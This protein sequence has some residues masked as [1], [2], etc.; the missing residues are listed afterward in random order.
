MAA[1]VQEDEVVAGFLEHGSVEAFGRGLVGRLASAAAVANE[2][3]EGD[4]FNFLSTASFAGPDS[5]RPTMRKMQNRLL[6]LAQE[7][8]NHELPRNPPRVDDPTDPEDVTDRFEAVVDSTDLL[9]EKV[10]NFADEARGQSNRPKVVVTTT[11][12]QEKGRDFHL[13]H[14]SNVLRPQLQFKDPVDNTHTP[15]MPVPYRNGQRPTPA[16]PSALPRDLET[17]ISTQLGITLPEE[18]FSMYPHPFYEQLANLEYL[19]SQLGSCIEQPF[20]PLENVPLTFVATLKDLKDL[21][22]KLDAQTEFA[23]DL[24]HHS[25]RTFQGFTCLMQVSTRTEDFIV[26]TLALRE[27]MHLLSTSFHDAN[28]VKVFHGSDSDIMWLQRD[29][30]LYV[31][32]MFDTGQACRVLEYPSFSLAYLLRHHCGVLADKKYQVADWRIR[33]LP[34]EMLKYAREDTHY[35]LFIY[36]KLRNELIGRANMSNNLILAVLN[37]S[38]ELCLLQ[39]EK[40]LWTPTS[41]LS[42]YNRFNYVFNEQQMRVFAAVYKWRDTVAREE[43]ESYRYVL[44]NHMLF[45]VA[46]LVPTSVPALLACCNP[47][48]PLVRINAEILIDVITAARAE[49]SLSEGGVTPRWETSYR[50]LMAPTHQRMGPTAHQTAADQ[51]QQPPIA[52]AQPAQSAAVAATPDRRDTTSPTLSKDELYST[53]GWTSPR[54]SRAA[55][56]SPVNKNYRTMI[57]R[58]GSSLYSTLADASDS[59]DSDEDKKTAMLIASSISTQGLLPWHEVMAPEEESAAAPARGGAKSA[60]SAADPAM[61]DVPRSMQEIYEISNKN[62]KRNKEKRKLKETSKETAAEPF[63]PVKFSTGSDESFD[64]AENDT[65]QGGR[66]KQKPN[67]LNDEEFMKSIGWASEEDARQAREAASAPAPFD[68]AAAPAPFS[69]AQPQPSQEASDHTFAPRGSRNAASSSSSS[70]SGGRN[71]QQRPAQ[72]SQQAPF[73]PHANL[74]SI[75]GPR[76]GGRGRFQ[77]KDRSKTQTFGAARGGENRGQWPR[78]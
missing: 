29:F 64:G 69:Q 63:S 20:Q 14:G 55:V 44:P 6:R 50:P 59:D 54:S 76:G 11:T 60:A 53:A 25:Y 22:Q 35:L 47:V 2:L 70:A 40:P 26:D 8:I 49:P 12:T 10:D 77:R 41:H 68:Y 16:P 57:P 17:H 30:G 48:P 38:R 71:Q 75:S 73:D 4:D 13:F 33:P 78:R 46:E 62:R 51:R 67:D 15:W 42:L 43:D 66:K 72:A 45:H 3:P 39:Y 9:L 24:E 28:I 37:R 19:P 5:F 36:D 56:C 34:E 18:S 74:N 21:A 27:H 65:M 23:V 7:L 61:A 32:N 1:P 52:Q 31:I 58:A